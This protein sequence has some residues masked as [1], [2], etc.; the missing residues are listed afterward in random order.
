[1]LNSQNVPNLVSPF[2]VV[3]L[4]INTSFKTF[5]VFFIYFCSIKLLI[6]RKTLKLLFS[7]RHT[8]HAK[9]IICS[10]CSISTRESSQIRVGNAIP[11]DETFPFK[12]FYP[13]SRRAAHRDRIYC[14]LFL[15]TDIH[16]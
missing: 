4:Y 1:M 10:I 6:G 2:T 3:K 7:A 9:I 16:S 14:D 11:G 5:D 8:P 12:H 15:G 13:R